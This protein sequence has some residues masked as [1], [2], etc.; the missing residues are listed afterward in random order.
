MYASELVIEVDD[1]WLENNLQGVNQGNSNVHQMMV[2]L[3]MTRYQ[4]AEKE[5]EYLPSVPR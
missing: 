5:G 2:L 4:W 1:P 3:G